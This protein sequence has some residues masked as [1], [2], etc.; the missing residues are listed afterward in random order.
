MCTAHART[1]TYITHTYRKAR[2]GR[3]TATDTHACPVPILTHPMAVYIHVYIGGCGC[4]ADLDGHLQPVTDYTPQRPPPL[5]VFGSSAAQ[6]RVCRDPWHHTGPADTAAAVVEQTQPELRMPSKQRQP[7]SP[8]TTHKVRLTHPPTLHSLCACV[9]VRVRAPLPL[10][11]F[12]LSGFAPSLIP[13][14]T[15]VS[16][17]HSLFLQA[18]TRCQRIRPIQHVVHQLR[19]WLHNTQIHNEQVRIQMCFCALVSPGMFHFSEEPSKIET[20]D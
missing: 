9:C 16:L 7:A 17:L 20:C 14:R 11:H 5:R 18:T 8:T 13:Y 4:L 1:R 15:V 10:F 2:R 6:Q 12:I 3:H 19:R